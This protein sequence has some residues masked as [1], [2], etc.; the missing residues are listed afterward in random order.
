MIYKK[1]YPIILHVTVNSEDGGDMQRLDLLES[2]RLGL[3]QYIT[4]FLKK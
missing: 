1:K 3:K 4:I 2:W